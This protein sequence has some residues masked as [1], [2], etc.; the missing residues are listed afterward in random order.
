M[1][2]AVFALFIV[3]LLSTSCKEREPTFDE[4]RSQNFSSALE[5]L[6]QRND[7]ILRLRAMVREL[8]GDPPIKEG[9]LPLGEPFEPF[10]P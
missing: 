8:R 9:P 10:E 4:M 6:K 1:N 7:E 2:R 3:S 5:H